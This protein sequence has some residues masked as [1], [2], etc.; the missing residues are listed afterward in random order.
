MEDGT[1]VLHGDLAETA[2]AASQCGPV[3]ALAGGGA[4]RGS[5]MV[6]KVVS[7]ATATE[8]GTRSWISTF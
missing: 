4:H 1:G 7:M 3:T 5:Q 2:V 8:R 6:E